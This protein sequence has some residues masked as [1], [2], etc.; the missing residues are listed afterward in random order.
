MLPDQLSARYGNNHFRSGSLCI[1]DPRIQLWRI[2]KAYLDLRQAYLHS[3]SFMSGTQSFAEYLV[4]IYQVQ[5]REEL[6]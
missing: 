2:T 1:T 5:D 6:R 3:L 4:K